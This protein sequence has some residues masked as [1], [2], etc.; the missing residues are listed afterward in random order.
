MNFVEVHEFL[1]KTSLP[2]FSLTRFEGIRWR[3]RRMDSGDKLAIVAA[4]VMPHAIF[5]VIERD[6]GEGHPSGLFASVAF[7]F[8]GSCLGR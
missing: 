5:A 8:Y 1:M 6:P 7:P 2:E 4:G 3:L